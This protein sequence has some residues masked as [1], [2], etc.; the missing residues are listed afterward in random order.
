MPSS[1]LL[2]MCGNAERR[3]KFASVLS[4]TGWPGVLCVPSMFEAAGF[5]RHGPRICVIVDA[6]LEDIPGLKAVE[7]VRNLCPHV[8]IIFTAQENSRDLEAQV[9]GLNVFYYYIGSADPA[10]RNGGAA[11]PC[12]TSMTEFIEAVKDAIGWPTH[13]KVT[14]PPK[15]LIVDDDA[16]FHTAIREMLQPAGYCVVSAYSEPE[17]LVM[18]RREKPHVILL[19]IIMQSTTDGFE[20]CREARRDPLIKHTPILGISAFTERTG[21]RFSA[22]SDADLFPVDGYLSKPVASEQLFAELKKLL[23]AEA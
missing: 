21:L 17:G 23:S 7:I 5:L 1:T 13:G 12:S 19:D 20:F 15:V 4:G 18:A 2:V 10:P 11:S 3:E 9:R 6:E 22:D 16:D 14:H 8:K